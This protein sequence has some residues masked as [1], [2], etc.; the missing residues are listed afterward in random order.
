MFSTCLQNLIN[1]TVE[2]FG[3]IDCLINNAGWRKHLFTVFGYVCAEALRPIQ[4]LLIMS[5]R[6]SVF[7]SC[8][9]CIKQRITFL[10]RGQ[11]TVSPV[12]LEL[13]TLRSQY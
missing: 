8:N 3:Q 2:R 4:H 12:S 13:V 5:R 9:Q 10:A 6:F 7:L 1:E 11:N